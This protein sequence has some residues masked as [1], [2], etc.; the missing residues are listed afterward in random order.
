MLSLSSFAE[1]V[2]KKRQSDKPSSISLT[3]PVLLVDDNHHQ[4]N[5]CSH[6][7][8]DHHHH[9]QQ[10]TTNGSSNSSSNSSS[11][12]SSNAS[13]GNHKKGL[14]HTGGCRHRRANSDCGLHQSKEDEGGD[15][16]GGC[17]TLLCIYDTNFS[18]HLRSCSLVSLSNTPPANAG[19][20]PD[21]IEELSR[22]RVG[23]T[24]ASSTSRLP[25][26]RPLHL[27][28]HLASS[29]SNV[30]A[31]RGH[32]QYRASIPEILVTGEPGSRSSLSHSLENFLHIIDDDRPR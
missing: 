21:Y 25:G 8:M 24:S 2:T 23:I 19:L 7:T 31:N 14:H 29:S 1:P 15:G 20:T 4:H 11:S 28:H 17:S 6:L 22:Q 30:E 10:R 3:Q 12:N 9:H 18:P 5:H 13:C 26:T 27:P 16:G 32:H